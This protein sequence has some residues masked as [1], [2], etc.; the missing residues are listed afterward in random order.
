LTIIYDLVVISL[1]PW[2]VDP[3]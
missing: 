3:E 1:N 2:Q